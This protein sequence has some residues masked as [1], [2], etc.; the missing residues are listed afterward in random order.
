MQE[1]GKVKASAVGAV[2][3]AVVVQFRHRDTSWVHIPFGAFVH[4]YFLL[5]FHH[6]FPHKYL[7]LKI[8]C[9]PFICQ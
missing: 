1:G 2:R 3:G 6:F 8:M 4:P 9:V 5:L 7:K